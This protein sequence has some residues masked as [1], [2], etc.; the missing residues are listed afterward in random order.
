MSHERVEDA[1]SQLMAHDA[2]FLLPEDPH[3]RIR[4]CQLHRRELHM[5]QAALL[6]EL[7][8]V[9]RIEQVA[10]GELYGSD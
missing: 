1:V 4:W 9:H 10:R 5:A 2:D 7:E 8:D 3:D 6:E